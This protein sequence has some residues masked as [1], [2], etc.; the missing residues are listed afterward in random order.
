MNVADFHLLFTVDRHSRYTCRLCGRHCV[1]RYVH[2]KLKLHQGDRII[3][4]G[5]RKTKYY[6]YKPR[7]V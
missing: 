1:H 7:E 4:V 6:Y 3:R 5:H 2:V